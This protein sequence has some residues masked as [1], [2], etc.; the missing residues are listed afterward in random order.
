M[1]SLSLEQPNIQLAILLKLRP[2]S[3][4]ASMQE[5]QDKY[6]DHNRF[7]PALLEEN[8]FS[9]TVTA[10]EYKKYSAFNKASSYMLRT[11]K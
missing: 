2:N 1:K 11:P 8:L 6:A 7:F 9:W 10:V 3:K 4:Q 5:A